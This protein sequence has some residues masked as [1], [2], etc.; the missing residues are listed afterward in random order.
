MMHIRNQKPVLGLGCKVH[1]AGFGI[2]ELGFGSWGL[3]NEVHPTP[4][5]QSLHHTP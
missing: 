5:P 3:G 2:S 4:N 1:G